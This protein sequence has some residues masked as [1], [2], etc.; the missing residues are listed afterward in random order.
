MQ[1]FISRLEAALNARAKPMSQRQLGQAC[2]LSTSAVA[3]MFKRGD[4]GQG[5]GF[6][7]VAKMCDVLGITPNYLAGLDDMKPVVAG[8]VSN[9][10]LMSFAD[11]ILTLAEEMADRPSLEKMHSLYLR[12]GARLE[13]FS[14]VQEYFDLFELPSVHGR[15]VVLRAGQKSLA[16]MTIGQHGANDLQNAIDG[17]TSQDFHDHLMRDYQEAERVGWC[18]SPFMEMDIVSGS[19][20]QRIKADYSRLLL[21]VE[22]ADGKRVILNYAKLIQ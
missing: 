11:Q 8:P 1:G 21:C 20:N 19:I 18:S 4:E 5:P 16:T 15:P 22:D 17:V 10:R 14:S 9:N 2:G 6:F 12:G 7:R 13:A 3:K